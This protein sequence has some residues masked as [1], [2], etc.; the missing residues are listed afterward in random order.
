MKHHFIYKTTNI[1]TGKFYIGLHSTDNLE[2]DYMGSG[3]LLLRSIKK[4]GVHNF[5]RE[6]LEF[7]NTREE[8]GEREIHWVK[9]L[10]A[11]NLGYN[12]S[13]GGELPPNRK[14]S[15]MTEESKTKI[16][17]SST[18]RR[19]TKESILKMSII[20][21]GHTCTVVSEETRRKISEANSGNKN[22]MYGKT[23][24][25]ETKRKI[26]ENVSVALLGHVCSEETKRKI[27]ESQKGERNHR[28]GK[29]NTEETRRKISEANKG[30][31]Y[32]IYSETIREKMS[33]LRLG[34]QKTICPHC[35]KEGISCMK[36]W[37][38]D[39]CKLK[40]IAV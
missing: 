17:I 12:L 27:S 7:C 16:C 32:V 15:Y 24:T 30:K 38:F 18:G 28:Y 21:L 36:R 8:L 14:G 19:H 26:G 4:H 20:K 13:S 31:S 9:E 2:D 33:K 5:K 34:M 40:N 25:E 3:V 23:H 39:N 37:H 29:T 35:G 22:C 11:V 1:L 6:I 10:D